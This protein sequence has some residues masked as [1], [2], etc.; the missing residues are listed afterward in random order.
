[1]TFSDSIG[2]R[3]GGRKTAF[4]LLLFALLMGASSEDALAI[5][6]VADAGGVKPATEEK[7]RG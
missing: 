7:W 6:C 5:D 1:M 3:A 2:A 4:L